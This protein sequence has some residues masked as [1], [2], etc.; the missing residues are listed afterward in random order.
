MTETTHAPPIRLPRQR[1][2]VTVRL[3]G[4]DE[5]L[6]ALHVGDRLWWGKEFVAEIVRAT[7]ADIPHLM[8]IGE[9]DGKPVADAFLVGKGISQN[10]YAMAGLYVLPHARRRGVGR[11]MV[12]A[13]IDA[14]AAYS[15]PGI[16]INSHEL[17]VES[18][19]AARRLGFESMGHHR[20]S[21][22]DLDMLD[23]EVVAAAEKKAADAGFELRLLPDDATEED[24][25]QAHEVIGT[26]WRDAP[27]SEGSD[28]GPPYSIMRAMII[29][30]EQL[31]L[32]W[33]EGQPVGATTV[34]VR[35][36][37]DALNTW[38]TGV[39]R[40]AR[41]NGLSTALKARHAREMR[42]RGHHRIF[43]QNMSQNARILAANDRLGFTVVPGYHTMGRAVGPREQ[44]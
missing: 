30:P 3:G 13:L 10:G 2:A 25:H 43:T 20:E 31:L 39:L 19:T 7:P 27:D 5:D 16:A 34:M 22:L 38:F 9:L 4:L 14:C 17:E 28:E 18:L 33:R 37:D 44:D 12:D 35:A 32:A 41:G 15:V 40:E 8:L 24:W 11:A 26:A 6:D 1:G 29:E 21:V 42:D 23:D 36:K